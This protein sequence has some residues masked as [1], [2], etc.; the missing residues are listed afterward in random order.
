[1]QITP[2]TLEK[3]VAA[4]I[5]TADQRDR[6]LAFLETLPTAGPRFDFT[7]LL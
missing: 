3:A 4:D 7:H 1:M 5:I 2:Q 6:L